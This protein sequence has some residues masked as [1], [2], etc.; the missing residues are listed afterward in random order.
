M[1]EAIDSGVIVPIADPMTMA[2][3]LWTSVHGIASLRIAMPDI[4]WPSVEDQ[5]EVLFAML[6]NGMCAHPDGATR[7]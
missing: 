5:V 4:P 6:A 7:T 1:S 2:T 3:M